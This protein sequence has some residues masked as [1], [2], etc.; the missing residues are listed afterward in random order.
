VTYWTIPA[1]QATGGEPL[2]PAARVRCNRDRDGP[3][4]QKRS[5]MNLRHTKLSTPRKLGTRIGRVNGNE[6]GRE[7]RSPYPL[8]ILH[9]N[10]YRAANPA[11][12]LRN[13]PP[14]CSRS[15]DRLVGARPRH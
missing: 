5:D 4:A 3:V 10:E 11:S 15:A 7:A 8:R 2:C 13:V 12:G 6:S 9:L 1:T 14:N